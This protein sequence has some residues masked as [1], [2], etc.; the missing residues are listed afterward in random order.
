[1]NAP[2]FEVY[3]N[4][5]LLTWEKELLAVE[6]ERVRETRDGHLSGEVKITT[7]ATGYKPLIHRSVFSLS[8]Q[9]ARNQLS[10][11]LAESYGDLADWTVVLEQLYWL[12]ADHYRAGEPVLF[13]GNSNQPTDVSYLLYPI[14]QTN[15]PTL[16]Y[17]EGAA[18]KSYLSAWIALSIQQGHESYL[19]HPLQS[20]VLYLDWE[21]D[22]GT[23]SSRVKKLK[24]G[25]GFPEDATIRY[26]RCWMSLA[27][28]V[29]NIKRI[30]EE[31]AVGFAV[32]DSCGGA[33]GGD[34]NLPETVNRFFIALRYLGI[35]TLL[36]HNV[37]K[38]TATGQSADKKS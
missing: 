18:G 33:C 7:T 13:G 5:Y 24:A 29:E 36:I 14:L 8:S 10:R 11:A 19:W 38:N 31:H 9:N 2:K 28:D 12:I 4:Y 6:V 21:T 22:F 23:F 15:Q 25:A 16:L 26:R 34:P 1:M 35:T 3:G 27:D 37:P 17:G 30:V 20:N 32:V